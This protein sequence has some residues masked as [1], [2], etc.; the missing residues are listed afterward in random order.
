MATAVAK[1]GNS[2]ASVLS[3]MGISSMVTSNDTRTPFVN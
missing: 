2:G 3:G 1:P